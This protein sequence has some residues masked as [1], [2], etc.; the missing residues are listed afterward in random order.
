MKDIL[1]RNRDFLHFIC[2]CDEMC[3]AEGGWWE[4]GGGGLEE[5]VCWRTA[6]FFYFFDEKLYFYMLFSY[7]GRG[8][9]GGVS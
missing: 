9:G 5:N 6:H 8:E 4:R 2:F 3:G 7:E 1:A